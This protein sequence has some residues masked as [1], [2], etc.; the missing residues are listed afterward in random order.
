MLPFISSSGLSPGSREAKVQKA[1]VCL[2]CM[3]PI[4]YSVIKYTC[5]DIYENTYLPN[6]L[7]RVMVTAKSVGPGRNVELTPPTGS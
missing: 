2:N 7:C 1:R 5:D 4:R 6:S 3:E